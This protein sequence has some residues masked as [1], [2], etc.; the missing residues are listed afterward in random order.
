M[1]IVLCAWETTKKLNI[2]TRK[3]QSNDSRA[4]RDA[5]KSNKD[6]ID[7]RGPVHKSPVTSLAFICYTNMFRFDPVGDGSMRDTLPGM[8]ETSPFNSR[9]FAE[10]MTPRQPCGMLGNHK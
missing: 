3:R 9:L 5:C 6:R 1:T 2:D 4:P 7:T 10:A 8:L